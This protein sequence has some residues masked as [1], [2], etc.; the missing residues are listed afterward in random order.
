MADLGPYDGHTCPRCDYDLRGALA[1][2]CPECGLPLDVAE[3]QRRQEVNR[4]D[5]RF[6]Q[7]MAIVSGAILALTILADLYFTHFLGP[8]L[9]REQE[10][11]LWRYEG[12]LITTSAL[13]VLPIQLILLPVSFI[14]AL[15]FLIARNLRAGLFSALS[16][17]LSLM[18]F[19]AALRMVS[20][21]ID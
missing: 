19:W 21:F 6:T 20:Q 18:G 17:A 13:L 15:A 14:L 3:L 12:D 8:R 1:T 10:L 11:P 4:S 7:W 2:A 16:L 5:V 9:W